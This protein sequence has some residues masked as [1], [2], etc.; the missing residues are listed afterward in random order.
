MRQR[1]NPQSCAVV[2]PGHAP[3]RVRPG[4]DSKREHAAE[5]TPANAATPHQKTSA[6]EQPITRYARRFTRYRQL[7]RRYSRVPGSRTQYAA[8]RQ[9]E[10][11]CDQIAAYVAASQAPQSQVTLRQEEYSACCST[12]THED[13]RPARENR[14]AIFA[15]LPLFP[16]RA[17]DGAAQA[18][19]F[20]PEVAEAW[21]R[22]EADRAPATCRD[23]RRFPSEG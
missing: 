4:T 18:A 22:E 5:T 15:F 14:G 21:R 7:K 16:I 8:R 12:G 2:P 9:P 11:P 6:Y 19:F 17:P 23:A 3:D 20:C 13:P 1:G 10:P